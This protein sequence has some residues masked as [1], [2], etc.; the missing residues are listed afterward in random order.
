MYCI[1]FKTARLIFF[2]LFLIALSDRAKA[3]EKNFVDSLL[4]VLRNTKDGEEL[5]KTKVELGW[6]YLEV[7]DVES[8]RYASEAYKL[9][10]QFTDSFRIVKAGRIMGHSLRRLGRLRES[11][12]ILQE[13]RPIASRNK[14]VDEYKKILNGL[15][16]SYTFNAEYDKALEYNFQSLVLREREGDKAEISVALNNIG[17]VYFKLLNFEG[18]LEYYN[19][20]LAMKEE[21]NDTKDLDFLYLNLGLCYLQLKK[22]SDAKQFTLKAIEVCGP[23]CSN[24][25]VRIGGEYGLGEAS[26]HL[27]DYANAEVHLNKSLTRARVE[28]DKRWQA[29]S[30]VYLAATAIEEKEY[31]LAINRLSEA[32]S[33]AREGGFNQ[34]L[35]EGYRFAS[36]LY[37]RTGDYE[38]ASFFQRKLID[39]SD[40]LIGS[41]LVRK[42]GKIQ[43]NYEERRNIA[44]IA[45]KEVVISQQRDLNVAIAVIAMLA[46]LL[47]LV[48]QFGNRNIKR[49]N[50]KLSEAKEVIQKQNTELENKNRE[51]DIEV[52]KKTIDL[53]RVNQS[54]KQVNDELDN[55]IYKTSHDIRGPLAS[56]KGMCNVALLDVKDPI[57]LDYLRKLDAT[58]ER[59][60]SILTRLVIINQINNSKLT[61]EPIDFEAIVHDVLMLEKKKGLPP[62]LKISTYIDPGAEMES[63]KELVRIVLENLIDN[64]IKFYNDSDRVDSFMKVHISS[65]DGNAVKVRV[66]DNG[67]GISESSPG[68]LFQ[69]FSRASERSETGGIGLYITK[70]A[71]EKI[72]G[73]VGLLTT[74]EGHTEFY[75]IF[76][77]T[78]Y[79]EVQKLERRL[80]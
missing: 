44:T 43:V 23:N 51:L 65:V 17:L 38:K 3:Q 26:F 18:A 33:I 5:L 49:V 31:A 66:I 47:V 79:Y 11:I 72:G 34:I 2:A 78:P 19:K 70:T 55:F 68:K 20:C 80:G 37:T 7:D 76:P 40:S 12:T 16:V 42:I 41:E 52:D 62:E 63:D 71:T 73:R 60:N 61:I 14:F 30:L 25:E 32:D 58:A 15:A 27:H 28:N 48:L 50:A 39:L 9:A 46:G 6:H 4:S 67:I 13:V 64:A 1:F 21:A 75:V 24:N 59:L 54:L 29:E 53:A 35:I 8:F 56:L 57:A 10:V 77:K 36:R 22:Y 69:M 45:S 74:P